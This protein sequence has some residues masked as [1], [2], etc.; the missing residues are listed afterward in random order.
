VSAAHP[1]RARKAFNPSLNYE[2]LPEVASKK[3]KVNIPA[4]DPVNELLEEPELDLRVDNEA[5]DGRAQWECHACSFLNS[6][7]LWQCEMCDTT[8]CGNLKKTLLQS[9]E[10]MGHAEQNGT[11]CSDDW[12]SLEEACNSWQLCDV[13]SIA[14]SWLEVPCINDESDGDLEGVIILPNAHPRKTEGGENCESWSLRAASIVSIG[15]APKIPAA[16]VLMPPV[17][18]KRAVHKRPKLDDIIEERDWD[19]EG[20]E[21]RRLRGAVQQSRGAMQRR[22][23]KQ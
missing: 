14:S 7:L 19:L 6:D 5:S 10:S 20:L 16:G 15:D 21:T 3:E 1:R 18:Q 12:P 9:S 8:R 13:S 4:E 17:F 23:R 11:F 2:D 22:L